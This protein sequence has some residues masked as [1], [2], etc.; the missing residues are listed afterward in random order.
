MGKISILSASVLACL[1][2]TL[3]GCG[4][5][6]INI[7][8]VET[9]QAGG[10]AISFP[11]MGNFSSGLGKAL[12]DKD[13]TPKDVDSMTV[14][15]VSLTLTSQGGLTDDL[16][17]LE[18]MRFDV[19]ADG[20]APE[21]LANHAAFADGQRQADFQVTPDL[22]LKPFLQAGTMRIDVDADLAYPPPD[23][24]ELEVVFK[25][26]IDVNVI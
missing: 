22:E 7:K 18:N 14:T 9:G 8:V 20:L 17:F 23:V 24:V 21:V 12:S 13:V 11:G 25:L 6:V 5:D 10:L 26:R 19:S 16:T 3:I 4:A 2:L 15:D 1:T